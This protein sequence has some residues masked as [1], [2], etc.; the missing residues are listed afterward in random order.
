M[1]P[2]NQTRAA[3]SRLDLTVLTVLCMLL[4]PLILPAAQKAKQ[5]AD[6]LKCANNLKSLALGVLNLH[7]TM[8]K[9]P[10]LVGDFPNEKAHGTVFFHMLPYVEQDPLYNSSEGEGKGHFSIW[11]NGIYSK[12]VD[13]FLCPADI[14]GDKDKRY[15]GWLALSSYAANFLVFGDPVNK[16]MQGSS[17]IASITDGLSNTIFFA[18]RYQICNGTP[19]GWGYAGESLQAPAFGYLSYSKFQDQPAQKDCDATLTQAIHPGGIMVA[20]GDGSVR[21]VRLD[22]SPDTWWKAI[23]PDDGLPLDRDW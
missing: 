18:E 9:F 10:P 22:L 19:N 12:V 2:P 23:V 1:T 13:L 4:C 8:G 20:L 16:T 11:N 15:E 7:D 5:N 14:S 3:F 21:S 17:T 6:K